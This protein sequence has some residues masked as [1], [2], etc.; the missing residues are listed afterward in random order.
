MDTMTELKWRW[1]TVQPKAAGRECESA[2]S[3]GRPREDEKE[4]RTGG[5]SEC[6]LAL[7]WDRPRAHVKAGRK[8]WKMDTMTELKWGWRTARPK[9]AGRECESASRW[10]R[11]RE[12]EK[13]WT[14]GGWSECLLALMWDLPRAHVKA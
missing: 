11:P 10:G 13:E 6:L 3:W 2:S 7:M 4:W 5:W 1:R 12:D 14:T 8:A 9:A